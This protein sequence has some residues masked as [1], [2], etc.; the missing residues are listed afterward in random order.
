MKGLW[1]FLPNWDTFYQA[2]MPPEAMIDKLH[3]AEQLLNFLRKVFTTNSYTTCW[4][5]EPHHCHHSPGVCIV[6][7]KI[8]S[9]REGT[10]LCCPL[11]FKILHHVALNKYSMNGGMDR[12]TKFEVMSRAQTTWYFLRIIISQGMRYQEGTCQISFMFLS[13][14][15]KPVGKDGNLMPSVNHQKLNMSHNSLTNSLIIYFGAR[16]WFQFELG[17]LIVV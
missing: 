8:S 9:L 4:S 12:S 10:H 6:H 13:H 5:L 14:E 16:L 1:E 2:K 15:Y 17:H 11:H 3:G 7:K